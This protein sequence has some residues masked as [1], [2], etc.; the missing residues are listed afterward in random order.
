MLPRARCRMMGRLARRLFSSVAALAVAGTWL[1]TVAMSPAQAAG[2][3][4]QPVHLPS[5]GQVA[6]W[7]G[8]P[9][10]G[11]LPAQ[12]G[13]TAAGHPHE[14]P[15]SVTRAHRGAGHAPGRGRG[16]LRPYAPMRRLV[17]R[18]LSG[19]PVVG[20]VAGTSR[21]VPAKSTATSDWY[22][23]A[24][25]SYTRKVAAGPINYRDVTGRWR[26][27]DTSLV[28][29]PDGRWH[30]RANSVKVDLAPSA[31]AAALVH[32]GLS[33]GRGVSYGL[34]GAAPAPAV[35]SR[36]V[37][38]YPG[39]LPGTDLIVRPTAGGTQ[40]SLVLHSASAAS[41][42]AFPLALTGLAPVLA[43]SGSVDLVGSSGK[44]EAV[45]PAPYAYDSKISRSPGGPATTHA[46]RYHLVTVAGRPVLVLTLNRGWLDSPARVFPVTVDPT[47][48]LFPFST[49]AESTAPG[50]HSTENFIKVGSTNSGPDSADAF[51]QF[52]GSG[53]DGSHVTISSA[54]LE[55]F[56]TFASTCTPERFD[57]APVTTPWTPPGVISYPGPSYG[58]SM[59]NATPTVTNACGNTSLNPAVGDWVTVPL[60][61]SVVQGWAN[62]STPDDGMAVYAATSDALHWKEFGSV[63]DSYGLPFLQI[64]YTGFVLPGVLS[65]SPANGYTAGTLTPLLTAAGHVDPGD[66]GKLK[67]DFQVA[68]SSGTRVADSGLV[69]GGL[70]EY[71][72]AAWT[73]PSGKLKWGEAYYWTVQAYDGTN[74]S[75]G[76]VWNALRIDVPQPAVTSTL[77][78]NSGPYGF[79][80]SIGNYTTEATDAQVST[81]GPPLKVVR[82]YNSRDPR[83]TGGFGASWS[84]VF[85]AR[86][87]EQYDSTG[88]VT[89]V[90]VTYPDGSQVG[91]GKNPDGTFSPPLG[92][93]ATFKAIIGGYSL[94]DKN[95]TVYTFTQSLGSGAFGIT[96][97]T[98]ALG[99]V[100]NFTWASGEITAVT[101]AVSGRALHLTWSAPAGAASPHV[102]TIATDPVVAGQPSTALTWAYGYSGDQLTS[103]CPPGTATACTTYSYSP[104][105][106]YGSAVLD[107]GAQSLWPLAET[108]G[109]TAASAVLAN[110]GNDNATYSNV[111]L[112]QPGPLAGST[113]TAAGFNGTSSLVALPNL[114]LY[115]QENETVSLWFKTLAAPGVLMSAE[116][117][118][119]QATA[120]R[121]NFDPVLYIGTDGKLNGLIWPGITPS[122][123]VSK[124]AVNDGNWH[125][126]VLA[127]S[128]SAQT[129]WLDGT[130]VG[131][132]PGATAVGFAPA[133]QPWILGHDFLGT[134]YLGSNWPDQPH[135]N[136]STLFATYF[137]GSI[138]DAA[139]FTRALTQGNVSALWSAGT[140]QA[141]LLNTIALPSGK[142][143]AAVSYDPVTATVTQVTDQNGGVWKLAPP[144]VTGS[145]EVYRSSVMG[146]GPAGYWRLREPAGATQAASEVNYT[147]GTYAN[148][149]LGGPGPFPDETAAGFNGSSSSV[150]M[151]AGLVSGTGNQSV[152]LWFKTTAGGGPLFGSSA[153]PLS[154]GSATSYTP[155]LYVGTSGDL[156]GEFWKGSV[157]PIATS[158][159]VTDGQ[160]HNV[161]L[162]AGTSSQ[163]LY[164]DGKLVGTLAGTISGT[165]QPN[166]YT[167][168]GFLGG[169]WPDEANKGGTGAP[170]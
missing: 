137:N 39:V 109:T 19:H 48:N 38:T 24:D 156:Y 95:D 32:L 36:S 154:A 144:A 50:D 6:S 157:A 25:G 55:L 134:G 72:S 66:A 141:N 89:S 41:R 132:A 88:A 77:S 170:A 76:P 105:S 45:F 108:A 7:F 160:W 150:T 17:K 46:V 139:F 70:G 146:A 85:D 53:L 35:V 133:T 112:G 81:I 97:I 84:S 10:R 158:G 78:Q 51:V 1:L 26:P 16:Q 65:Q 142:I 98:D 11:R 163:S 94:T 135:P 164:L 73:V 145:S 83:I 90:V 120:T 69:S 27:I 82:D 136:S 104:G 115:N 23:N 93:F 152:S 52:P 75:P 21:L 91:F 3:R 99:R 57:V 166:V 126:V 111:T 125:H 131:T 74:F 28:K 107:G 123:I 71:G 43:R 124:S 34:A 42:W 54:S 22:K 12:A 92:R 167:G 33:A 151:P 159:P 67:F 44:T 29:G 68:D 121:G 13:G 101:S 86:A 130:L 63:Y 62:G 169:N 87:T 80:P 149:T 9:S 113:A 147:P 18:G 162:T 2:V 5:L 100:E 64:T 40:E 60:S 161:V 4:L 140:R 56:D 138:A 79:D 143:Q 15:A 59:G 114:G 165:G 96:S 155:E 61:T 119:I 20:Y 47:L 153:T 102:A 129:M 127:G 8:S 110:E 128:P 49:Y 148:V 30:E 168:A 117:N 122:P 14:V 31:A 37:V 103:V 106:Q 118:P 58:A 116:D